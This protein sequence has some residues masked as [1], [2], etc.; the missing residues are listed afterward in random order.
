MI[1]YG[2]GGRNGTIKEVAEGLTPGE[3]VVLVFKK[4][5]DRGGTGFYYLPM[6]IPASTDEIYETLLTRGH[7]YGLSGILRRTNEPDRT[8]IEDDLQRVKPGEEVRFTY[9]NSFGMKGNC[10]AYGALEDGKLQLSDGFGSYERGDNVPLDDL[11][12]VGN[13]HLVHVD[14]HSTGKIRDYLECAKKAPSLNRSRSRDVIFVYGD[15]ET[16]KLDASAVV[17]GNHVGIF[18]VD[19]SFDGLARGEIIE[20]LFELAE[21]GGKPLQEVRFG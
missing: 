3:A 15:G 11:L 12:V 8:T 14:T 16:V 1:N 19:A 18:E 20:D 10:F 2:T 13:Y 5:A 21:V 4:A 6:R 17:L 7:G 9:G